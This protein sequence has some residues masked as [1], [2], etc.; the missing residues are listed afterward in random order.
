VETTLGN[1]TQSEICLYCKPAFFLLLKID[2]NYT[3]GI[4]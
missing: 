4:V 2:I 1:T 3:A